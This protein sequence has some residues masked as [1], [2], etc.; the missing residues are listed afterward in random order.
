MYFVIM[1]PSLNLLSFFIESAFYS[2]DSF[3]NSY[4]FSS[5]NFWNVESPFIFILFL[6]YSFIEFLTCRNWVHWCWNNFNI[7]Y[8]DTCT[9]ATAIS[10]W[11]IG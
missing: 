8:I 4:F 5:D 9:E 11:N 3:H 7:W 10:S 6:L 1:Y 2:F